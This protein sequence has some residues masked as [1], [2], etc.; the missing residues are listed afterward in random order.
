MPLAGATHVHENAINM[1]SNHDHIRDMRCVLNPRPQKKKKKNCPDCRTIAVSLDPLVSIDCDHASSSLSL[2]FNALTT[3]HHVSQ[4][5]ED[6][7]QVEEARHRDPATH[8]QQ[9]RKQRLRVIDRAPVQGY[10]KGKQVVEQLR[11][12]AQ[13]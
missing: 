8:A 3:K 7:P 6:A 2:I 5:D 10:F 9:I 13:T 1:F 11:A 4:V 12:T